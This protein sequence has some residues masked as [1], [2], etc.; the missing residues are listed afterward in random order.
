[1]HVNNRHHSPAS[2]KGLKF[3]PH[4]NSVS[5]L[6]WRIVSKLPEKRHIKTKS[7]MLRS[8]KI[9]RTR[10]VLE[11]IKNAHHFVFSIGNWDSERNKSFSGETF[12]CLSFSISISK[13]SGEN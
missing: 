5:L 7:M 3:A 9:G 1:M 4:C 10:W 6:G 11:G 2:V 13:S 8:I 12:T